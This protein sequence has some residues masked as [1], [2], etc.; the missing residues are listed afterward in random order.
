MCIRDSLH[1][2][3]CIADD[4]DV[5]D[6]KVWWIYVNQQTYIVTACKDILSLASPKIVGGIYSRRQTDMTDIVFDMLNIVTSCEASFYL[7]ITF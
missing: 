7:L 4:G 5:D 2:S 6:E 3:W 1:Q